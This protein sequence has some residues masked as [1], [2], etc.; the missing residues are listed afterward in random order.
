MSHEEDERFPCYEID[1]TF[2][3]NNEQ[4]PF[5]EMEGR[6]VDNKKSEKSEVLVFESVFLINRKVQILSL[7]ILV[8]PL[9]GYEINNMF[10]KQSPIFISSQRKRK[11]CQKK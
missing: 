11:T 1:G 4:V 10:S 9:R 8:Q 7:L 2:L 3:E 5:W 6:V